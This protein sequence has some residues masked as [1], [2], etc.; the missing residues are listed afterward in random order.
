[1]SPL[2]GSLLPTIVSRELSAAMSPTGAGGASSSTRRGEAGPL[3]FNGLRVRMGI[4]TGLLPP[5]SA[6]KGSAAM[7]LAKS[8]WGGA[9]WV[10]GLEMH[11][12]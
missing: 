1:M 11:V 2:Q 7:D 4:T 12:I 10:A 3:L 9:V 8:G 6:A 5:G